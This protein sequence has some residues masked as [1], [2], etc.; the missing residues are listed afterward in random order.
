MG[1]WLAWIARATSSV[2]KAHG[3]ARGYFEDALRLSADYVPTRHFYGECLF[4]LGDLDG[5]EAQYR[6]HLAADAGEPDAR[7]GLGIVALERSQ[8]DVAASEFKAAITLYAQLGKT[9]PRKLEARRSSLAECHARIGD[10]FFA[11]GE[12]AAARD[13]LLESTRLEPRNISAF[14]TLSLVYRRLGDATKATQALQRYDS[15]KQQLLRRGE[16]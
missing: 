3:K 5:A 15:A 11:R 14:Y 2:L 10:V 13:A 4:M 7:Y 12:Y 16:G 1:T 9:H 8:L 6:A